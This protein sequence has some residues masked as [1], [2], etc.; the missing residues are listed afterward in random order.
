MS[1]DD[2][3]VFGG[4]LRAE[5]AEAMETVIQAV[6][7]TVNFHIDKSKTILFGACESCE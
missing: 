2:E 6:S 1:D 4:G 7:S 5:L 3:D